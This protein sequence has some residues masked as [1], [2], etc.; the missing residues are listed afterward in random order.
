[1]PELATFL[2]TNPTIIC[3]ELA[4]VRGS[5]PRAAGTRMLVGAHGVFGTIGGG[6]L[7]YMVIERARRMLERGE[8]VPVH[9]DVPLGPQDGPVLR[10]ARFG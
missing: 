10:R 3:A 6:A 9:M 4:S 7:E 2:E 8:G 5:S 1:M